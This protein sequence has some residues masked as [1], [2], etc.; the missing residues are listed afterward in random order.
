MRVL[1]FGDC[2]VDYY[3]H[4][5]TAYPGGNALNVAVFASENGM[6]SGF[7]GTVGTDDIGK[8]IM[9][10][11]KE[12]NI[13]I[14]R[15]RIVEGTSGKAAVNIVDGNRVF[16]GKYFGSEH[17]VGTLYP[18]VL[19]PQDIEYM[20]TYDLIHGSCYAHIEDE[21]LKLTETKALLTFD[22]SSEE[23]YRT[24]E[25]LRKL[26][27]VMDL[28]LFSCEH[29][30]TN[31]EIEVFARKVMFYGCKNV[32]MTMG[33][34]GQKLFAESGEVFEGKAELITPVDTM[35]AGDS[36]C[37]ALLSGMLKRGWKKNTLITKEIAIPAMVAAS[38]YSAKNCLVEGSFGSG[39]K[40]IM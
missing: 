20:S 12:K 32:L 6:D 24:D 39:L 18:P 3:I 38:E 5:H 31:E 30:V 35:G 28:A 11:A 7:L 13:D 23:R 22:F 1:G 29:M 37:A 14:S 2:C 33:P 8:H 19:K 4:K 21:F 16:D 25:Y 15:C 10:C 17:G 34:R 9:K 26:C 36:F 40:I 27:P